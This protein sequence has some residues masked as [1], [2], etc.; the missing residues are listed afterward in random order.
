MLKGKE[1]GKISDSPK[2]TKAEILAVQGMLAG[3]MTVVGI[4]KVLERDM[5]L[6]RAVEKKFKVNDVEKSTEVSEEP[7]RTE[8][9]KNVMRH[10]KGTGVVVLTQGGS[11]SGD[12][13]LKRTPKV[14]ARKDV[15]KI[16]KDV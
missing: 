1:M 6:I 9:D 10:K 5:E 16:N 7:V 8:I 14:P 11:E 3:G 2:L 12:T 13:V 4:A 15:F